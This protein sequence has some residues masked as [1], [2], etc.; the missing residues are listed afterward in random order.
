MITPW[1]YV[2]H[3]TWNHSRFWVPQQGSPPNVCELT[4]MEQ[5]LRP[6]HALETTPY[7]LPALQPP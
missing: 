1:D 2:L 7:E 4:Y 3:V 6:M 5:L